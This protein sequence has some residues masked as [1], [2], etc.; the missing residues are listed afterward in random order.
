[1][2]NYNKYKN[3]KTKKRFFNPYIVLILF[4]LFMMAL[5]LGY[6]FFSDILTIYGSANANYKIY[7]ITYNLNGGTNPQNPVTQYTIVDNAVLPLPTRNNYSFGGWYDN[8]SLNGTAISTTTGQKRD[9]VLYAKW[10]LQNQEIKVT[11]A[12]GDNLY[13]D[14]ASYMDTGLAIFSQDNL[15]RETEITA[16]I[17][18]RGYVDGQSS[19]YNTFINCSDHAKSPWPGFTFRGK[20]SGSNF[21]FILKSNNYANTSR[22]EK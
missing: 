19:G 12:F 13:F 20:K 15:G 9:L 7:T 5:A 14:G 16:S 4:T 6:S 1:M 18:N 10:N 8:E 21:N 3:K 11:Y 22:T 2:R 17:S